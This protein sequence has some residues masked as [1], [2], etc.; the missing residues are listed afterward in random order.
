MSK[1]TFAN[2]VADLGKM[3]G[4]PQLTID[5]DEYCFL[6]IDEKILMTL[7]RDPNTDFFTLYCELGSYDES[8]PE[9]FKSLLEAN[10]LWSGTGGIN[11]L[12]KTIL[13][14]YKH[15]LFMTDFQQFFSIVQTFINTAELL[16]DEILKVTKI[17]PDSMDKSNEFPLYMQGMKV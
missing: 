9:V 5:E 1:E 17:A 15:P 6:N 11:S 14:A 4:I 7:F 12:N 3:I 2:L 10:Y 16:I 8:N 13:M